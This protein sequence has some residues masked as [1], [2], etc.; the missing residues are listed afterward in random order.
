V[1]PTPSQVTAADEEVEGSR[2]VACWSVRE[3][4]WRDELPDEVAAL[5]APPLIVSA[6]AFVPAETITSARPGP[7]ARPGP[8]VERAPWVEPDAWVEPNAWME[9]APPVTG[10]DVPVADDRVPVADDEPAPV[11]YYPRHAAP[12][13][14]APRSIAPTLAR[15]LRRRRPS[16]AA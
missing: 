16:H 14:P 7:L 6:E 8:S 10:D 13:D 5:L 9:P 11:T 4:D 1:D 2:P 15:R 3:G 12:E